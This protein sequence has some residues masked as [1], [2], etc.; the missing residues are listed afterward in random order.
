MPFINYNGESID[1]GELP[2][3][4]S[5]E[6]KRMALFK[7]RPDA[8][9]EYQKY[10][11]SKTPAPSSGISPMS[12]NETEKMITNDVNRIK[13][14]Q[15][16][17]SKAVRPTQN[18][19][20]MPFNNEEK[21]TESLSKFHDA[22]RNMGAGGSESL[23][24]AAQAFKPFLAASNPNLLKAN[25]KDRPDFQK[26]FGV[27][28][29]NRAIQKIPEMAA[30]FI[31]GIGG[32]K[33]LSGASALARTAGLAAEQAGIQGGLGYAFNPESRKE[34][35]GKAGGVAALSQAA[36]DALASKNPVAKA[37]RYVA[38]RVAGAFVGEKTAEFAGLPTW[39]KVGLAGLGGL[40]GH[41]GAMVIPKILRSTTNIHG[42][43]YADDVVK[44]MKNMDPIE[45]KQTMETAKRQGI[46]LTPGEITQDPVLLAKES[47][48]G[49][50]KQNIQM[51]HVLEEGRKANEV[52]INE[53]FKQGVYNPEEH[54]AL[55]RKA[56]DAAKTQKV[57]LASL[58]NEHHELY[59]RSIQFAKRNPELSAELANSVHGSVGQFDVM[60][61]ALDKMIK[62]ESG[63]TSNLVKARTALSNS[64]KDFSDEYRTAM[65]L[66]EKGHV[67][68]TIS[69]L[70]N[71]EKLTGETFFKGMEDQKKFDSLV[72]HTRNV[73]GADQFL[74]DVRK[75]YKL[76]KSVDTTALAKKLSNSSVPTSKAEVGTFMAKLFNGKSDK[77]TIKLMY[78][79]DVMKKVHK[80]AGMN[81]H[82]KAMIEFARILSR[83][84]AQEV[85][86]T[87]E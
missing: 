5:S 50:N 54:D 71:K 19:E 6:Q 46:K 62:S 60:R 8:E 9:I 55:Q 10:I 11:A 87:K 13:S 27:Q 31:P 16:P 59:A 15:M 17:V 68:K 36:I 78:D 61:R 32:S 69:A 41:A 48:S 56:F 77:A 1:V 72:K 33:A 85:A 73:E 53:K 58:P 67:F 30:S 37:A 4:A 81:D 66:S 86:R 83:Q 74:D 70:Q 79:P 57:P 34:S 28:N 65:D 26:I 2:D 63:S 44:A 35:A 22:L 24:N 20:R 40:T 29:P 39:A 25:P 49:V 47:K 51:K 43:E 84:K 7:V 18:L 80:I 52:K 38:P 12:Q 42:K 64:L 23:Y 3:N 45:L 76:R 75:L 14:G 21:S 82:E